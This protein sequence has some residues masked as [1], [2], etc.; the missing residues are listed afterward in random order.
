MERRFRQVDV[1]GSDP[2]TGN[3]VAVVLDGEGLSGETMQRVANWT[4][5]SETTFVLPPSDPEADYLLRIFTPTSELPFAGHPTLGSAHAW[6]EAGGSP[7]RAGMV[8]QECGVGLVELRTTADRIAFAAPP[9]V[10]G[11]PLEDSLVEEL[12]RVLGVRRDDVLE[13]QWVDNGPGWVALLLG[14]AEQVLAVRPQFIDMSVGIVALSG[15]GIEVRAFFPANGTMVEDPVTGSLNASLAQ[16]LLD[17]GRI[18][19]PYVAS[20]GTALGRAGRV[21]IEEH[22]DRVWVGGATVTCVVGKAQL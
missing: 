18:E 11:G 22:E 14:S 15:E 4:N 1:F 20:Q 8:V 19:A 17:S 9:L 13:S 2:Y 21:F 5:L 3:P 7:R 6:L 10:R 16:W 12:I